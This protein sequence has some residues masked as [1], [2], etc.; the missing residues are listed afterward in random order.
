MDLDLSLD[1]GLDARVL[2]V[3]DAPLLVEATTGETG[4]SLWGARPVGPYTLTDAQKALSQW[5]HAEHGQFSIGI[6]RE[7][8]LVGAV[9]LMP[10]EDANVELAYWIRPQ[11]RGRGI[12][13][14]VVRA[15]TLWAHQ[16][17]KAPRIWLEINPSNEPSLRLARQAGYRFEQ[18][19]ARHCRD[20]SVDDPERDTWH[21]CLIWIY[22]PAA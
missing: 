20:W 3:D 17:L 12:G 13:S 5:N 22:L 6:L 14:R 8:Y 21:D 10:D 9:G 18:R 4:R 11:Q 1:A 15:V 19:L 2:T 7:R 16:T